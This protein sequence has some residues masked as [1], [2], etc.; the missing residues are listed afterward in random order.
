MPPFGQISKAIAYL[1]SESPPEDVSK[2]PIVKHPHNTTRTIPERLPAATIK[3]LSAL[4]PAKAV[5]ATAEEWAAI[6][7]AI[8]LCS[9]FWHPVLYLIAV[10]VIGSRQH[11]LLILG[12]DASHYRYLPTRWQN[13]LV[14][15]IFLMWPTF[16]SVEGFRKFHS[17]PS[18]VYE[19]SQRRKPAYLVYA[20]RHGR[21]R[22]W[23]ALSQDEGRARAGAAAPGLL[24]HGDV[25]DR[26][27]ARGR[28][29]HSLAALDDR[30]QDRVLFL[31]RRRP[32]LLRG[33]AGLLALLARAVLH[34]A[35]R[36]SICSHHLRA[37]RRGERRGRVCN[38]PDHRSRPSS[39][40]SSSCRGMSATT[41]SITGIRA[42]PSTACR[43][44]MST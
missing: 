41:S 4:E 17:N 15:N 20:R 7:A 30:L 3:E 24:C 1:R 28:F 43:I 32:D 39:S 22:A 37:Q 27:G 23:L 44:C 11:A 18:S 31:D 5:A 33:L 21:A 29:A 19:P 9:F 8:A 34:L 10:V 42:C 2:N 16:A 36:G 35:Y 14:A 25:L 38:H 6:I 12:H 13:D 26:Q 40:R